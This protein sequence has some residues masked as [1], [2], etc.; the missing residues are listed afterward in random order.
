MALIFR[1]FSV[2]DDVTVKYLSISPHV[3]ADF[4]PF[5]VEVDEEFIYFTARWR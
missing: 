2:E 3:G 5:S 4:P 1:L